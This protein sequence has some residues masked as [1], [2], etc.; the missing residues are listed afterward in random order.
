MPNLPIFLRTIRSR[1]REHQRTMELLAGAG[2][3]GQMVAILRQELDSMIR[4]IYLLTQNSGRREYLIGTLIRGEKWTRE[5]SRAKITDRDMVDLAQKL[6]GW[7]KSVYKFGCAFIHLSCLH[8]YNDRDPLLQLPEH[9]SS[10]IIEH[11]RYY[12]GGP[13]VGTTRFEDIVPYLPEVLKKISDNLDCYL[14]MLEDG[15]ILQ[16]SEI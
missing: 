8:D 7:T 10:D 6:Q 15:E 16:P 3:A 14:E 5:N 4:V 1:S 13:A 9:E 12:H 2:L 11:C